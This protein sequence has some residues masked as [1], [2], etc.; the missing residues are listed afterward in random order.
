M[1]IHTQATIKTNATAIEVEH[2]DGYVC[3][4][5][6]F[7][8]EDNEKIGHGTLSCL[9]AMQAR[10]LADYLLTAAYQVE[11]TGGKVA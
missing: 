8:N 10:G 5:V 4:D 11:R 1:G 9:T 7:L 2:L 6:S 3:L